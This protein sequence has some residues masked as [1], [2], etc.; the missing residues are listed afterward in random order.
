MANFLTVEDSLR[1][2]AGIF[3]G[4][5][6]VE[7]FSPL[8]APKTPAPFCPPAREGIHLFPMLPKKERP[9]ICEI[10]K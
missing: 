10:T 7:R 3:N 9:E 6:A 8:H 1:L 2:A 5:V 4:L